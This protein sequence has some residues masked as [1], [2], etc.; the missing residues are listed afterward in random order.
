[1]RRSTAALEIEETSQDG[2]CVLAFEGELD[3][4][5]APRFCAWLTAHR[6]QRFVV[7]LSHVGFCDS[8]GLRALLGEA[9]ECRIAGG[10]S[11]V[12]IPS[13]GHVRTLIDL[14]G[15]A[16]TLEVTDDLGVAVARLQR[17]H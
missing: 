10:R 8:S 17:K 7:D 13:A 4:A 3:L 16:S 11:V 2:V 5:T 9:Q 1:M 6:G 15:L 12:V 14:T